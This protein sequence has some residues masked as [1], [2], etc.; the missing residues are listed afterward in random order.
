[1]LPLVILVLTTVA[2]LLDLLLPLGYADWPLY[3]IP[4]LLTA[5][6]PSRRSAFY[7][8][9]MSSVLIGMGFV[10]SPPGIFSAAFFNRS[11][12]ICVLWILAALLLNTKRNETDLL[13]AKDD[14]EERVR[15]RTEALAKAI[16][17]LQDEVAQRTQAEDAFQA[18]EERF[19][20]TVDNVND[21]IMYLDIAGTV[22]WANQ[23][24][25]AL[26]GRSVKELTGLP[27]ATALS[28]ASAALKESR[29]E[30]VRQGKTVPSLVEF[31]IL[32]PDGGLVWIEASS[33]NVERNGAAQGR[34]LVARDITERK[35]TLS[36][37]IQKQRYED[38]VN[39]IDGIVW[40]AD[41]EPFR[42]TFVS[43]QSEKLLGYPVERWLSEPTF[44]QEH[45]HPEDR[46]DAID[47]CLT[48]SVHDHELD[49]EFRMI[50]ADQRTIWIRNLVTV[51]LEDGKPARLR[52]VMVDIT[53]RKLAV[54]ALEEMN[55]ALAHAMPGI[56]R[57][58]ALGRYHSVNDHYARMLGM[59]PAEL[60]GRPWQPT[61][62]ADDHAAALEAYDLML[63]SGSGEFEARAIR[64]DG[65]EFYKHVVMV[66]K[67]GPAGLPD[68]HYCF[69]KDITERRQAEEEQRHRGER[70]RAQR[71]A[72]VALTKHEA[73]HD[74]DLDLAC[75]LIAETAART[76]NVERTSLWLSS[77][78]HPAVELKHSFD[79]TTQD[80]SGEAD[81]G[82]PP[83]L[84]ALNGEAAQD[85]AEVR[86]EARAC[87]LRASCPIS[88]ESDPVLS[89]PIR[90]A[91]K[92]IGVLCLWEVGRDRLWTE[93]ERTFAGSLAT[94]VS[95]A[96]E[97]SH[98]K[99]AKTALHAAQEELLAQQRRE[100]E[101]VEEELKGARE[102]LVSQTRLATLGQLSGNIA[103]ELRNT[104]GAI[105]NA[106]HLLKRRVPHEDRRGHT[107]LDIVEE[108]VQ[109]GSRIITNLTELARGKSPSTRRA[110][111][112]AIIEEA[113]D[114]AKLT[115]G[116]RFHVIFDPDPFMVRA[117]PVQLGQV[118]VNLF[119]N[120]M[121]AL[122]DKGDIVLTASRD[123]D[124]DEIIVRDSGPGIAP[125]IR[126]RVFEP[127]FST[128]AKGTGLGLA[129]CRQILERHGGTIALTAAQEGGAAL[130]LRLPR[131]RP[132][133]SDVS[134]IVKTIEA[135][136]LAPERR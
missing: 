114:R 52:G 35:K 86:S 116:V 129:I 123:H 33:T 118:F 92:V 65:S 101:R 113:K 108:E 10:F 130:C 58:D 127:L 103:H 30:A 60:I 95:L 29:L 71:D 73:I 19:R 82:P 124:Y 99:Q 47:R 77:D 72:L 107:Y 98:R 121:Q 17:A 26:T 23:Q 40:E 91:G 54:Q 87:D 13:L 5:R 1:M 89:A 110:D 134:E 69:V 94:L 68:G 132:V 74:G 67:D 136:R 84:E 18:S 53:D 45:L 85:P 78:E 46:Q 14:L 100:R 37:M 63:R 133:V 25:Q 126:E 2:F 36:A 39:S 34:L 56:A 105:R 97:A 81:S 6:L 59:K 9:A 66:R 42:F 122:G 61:V 8:A 48:A 12:G 31:E 75:A 102:A 70:L 80:H 44:W 88:M 28:P 64:K 27:F 21:A 128:K 93:D 15:D 41:A 57:L 7:S 112:A 120:S 32:R 109:T 115:K 117:D 49:F 76:S 4:L 16:A 11:V 51:G 104:L 90:H 20:L 119:Q 50:A 96:I 38:L 79:L 22:R 125:E 106:L 24:T 131:E 3:L 43:P 111:L 135:S 83:C 55:L 62:H